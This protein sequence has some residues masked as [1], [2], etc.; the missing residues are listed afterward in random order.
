MYSRRVRI[1]AF[2]GVMLALVAFVAL[3]AATLRF[4]FGGWGT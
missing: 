3:G 2:L 1:G 4:L